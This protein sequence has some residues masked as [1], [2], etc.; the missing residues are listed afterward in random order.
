MTSV[1]F[2]FSTDLVKLHNNLV[3]VGFIISVFNQRKSKTW[4]P[5][6]KALL[7]FKGLKVVTPRTF[8]IVQWLRLQRVQCRG[9]KVQSVEEE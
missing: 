5:K 7:K 6:L 3:E 8:L 9:Q 1:V 4:L 2:L